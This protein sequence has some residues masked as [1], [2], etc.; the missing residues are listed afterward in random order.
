MSRE[1]RRHLFHGHQ[2]RGR[3][4]HSLRFSIA[5]NGTRF[6]TPNA[7]G[8]DDQS[9]FKHVPALAVV[10]FHRAIQLMTP[11]GVASQS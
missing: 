3:N 6:G 7:R 10:R 2:S 9:G 1:L 11:V 8:V 5:R 4:R